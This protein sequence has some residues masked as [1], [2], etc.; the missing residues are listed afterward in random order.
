MPQAVDPANQ[1]QGAVGVYDC[2]T[3]AAVDKC[4]AQI[5]LTRDK[6]LASGKYPE[7]PAKYRADIDLLLD[8]RRWLEI[9]LEE[10][11]C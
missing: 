8:R 9:L 4:I 10:A 11:P 5:V 6:I 2:A 1:V 7:L 3:L